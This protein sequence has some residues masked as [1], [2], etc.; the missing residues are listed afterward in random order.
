LKGSWA[1]RQNEAIGVTENLLR[2]GAEDE[3]PQTVPA[4]STDDHHVYLF[5]PDYLFQFSPYIA[6]TDDDL[7]TKPGQAPLLARVSTN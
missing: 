5:L 4:V 7:V 1:N 6:L 2:H 3:F